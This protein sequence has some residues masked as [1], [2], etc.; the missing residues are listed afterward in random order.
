MMMDTLRSHTGDSDP[1]WSPDRA[2]SGADVCMHAGWGPIRGSQTAGSMVSVLKKGEKP[3][4]WVTGT[5]APCTSIFKPVWM[6][7]GI[8]DSGTSPNG[9]YNQTALYWR[10]ETLHREILRDYSQ[11]I[12]LIRPDQ[13]LIEEELML[14]VDRNRNAS[15]HKRRELSEIAFT[16]AAE[17]EEKWLKTIIPQPIKR[18]NSFLYRIA[19]KKFNREAHMD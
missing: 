6:D 16:R 17:L 9:V 11:R 18:S 2:I 19:W 7:A 5:A 14:E 10:H 3:V 12:R 4:H 13:K 1:D 8:P 15:I